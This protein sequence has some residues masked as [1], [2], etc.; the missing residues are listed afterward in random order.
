MYGEIAKYSL[1]YFKMVCRLKQQAQKALSL[2]GVAFG[3]FVLLACWQMDSLQ[4]KIQVILM[5]L[6]PTHLEVDKW[7]YTNDNDYP[8]W[9]FVN[10]PMPRYQDVKYI[11]RPHLPKCCLCTSIVVILTMKI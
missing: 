10:R 3:I 2:T 9:K 7:E 4:N 8:W 5:H 6:V 1:E 11:R